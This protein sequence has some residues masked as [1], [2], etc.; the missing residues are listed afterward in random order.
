[1]RTEVGERYR[2]WLAKG[3]YMGGP[4]SVWSQL[5][6]DFGDF[7][8]TQVVKNVFLDGCPHGKK[9]CLEYSFLVTPET[10]KH[11]PAL[12]KLL[13]EKVAKSR[14]QPFVELEGGGQVV[15]IY[16]K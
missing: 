9:E 12:T 11:L 3:D 13:A 1:M 15:R 16:P 7:V 14:H 6:K 2:F 10:K 5:Q 8:E 4:T